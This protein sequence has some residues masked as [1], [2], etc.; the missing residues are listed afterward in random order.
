MTRAIVQSMRPKQ[1]TKNGVVFAGLI[2]SRSLDQPQM[3]LRAVAAVAIFCLLSG[4]VYLL[5]DVVDRK[6]DR[7][8]PRKKNRPIATGALPVPVALLVS[9]VFVYVVPDPFL[10]GSIDRSIEKID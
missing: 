9:F 7:A 2:F 1:W 8:H 6:V 10:Y 4:S 3:V 5:N